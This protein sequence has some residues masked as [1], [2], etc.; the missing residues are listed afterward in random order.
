MKLGQ[1]DTKNYSIL[2][3]EMERSLNE[4]KVKITDQ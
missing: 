4:W 3:Q 2:S 1:N